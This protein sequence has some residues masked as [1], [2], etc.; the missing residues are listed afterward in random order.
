MVKIRSATATGVKAKMEVSDDKVNDLIDALAD[1]P[2]GEAG[3]RGPGRPLKAARIPKP[4]PV[5]ISLPDTMI[6]RLEDMAMKNKRK[7]KDLK[8]VSAL[9]KEALEAKGYGEPDKEGGK[10]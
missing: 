4:T 9:V 5:T 3:R 10:S 7:K 6:E 1:K 8:T 2:Y